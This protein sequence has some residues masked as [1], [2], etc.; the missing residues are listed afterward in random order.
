MDLINGTIVVQALNFLVAYCIVRSLLLKPAVE[1]IQ[2]DKEHQQEL[3]TAIEARSHAVIDKEQEKQQQ[4]HL[5]QNR[6][7]SRIPQT[8]TSQIRRNVVP[9]IVPDQPTAAELAKLQQQV[10][11][12]LIERVGHVRW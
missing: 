12:A 8:I 3:M 1:R 2:Q 7:R 9:P 6:F 4:W 11:A 10:A 5:F